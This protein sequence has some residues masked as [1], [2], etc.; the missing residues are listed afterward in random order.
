VGG[1]RER[2]HLPR[3]DGQG[4][5]LVDAIIPGRSRMEHDATHTTWKYLS[6]GTP[7]AGI[8]KVVVK[9]LAAKLPGR[10]RFSIS[11]RLPSFSVA[12]LA[13]PLKGTVVLDPPNAT[14]GQCVETA[15]DGELAKGCAFHRATSPLK[16]K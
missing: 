10:V 2:G 3:E 4:G 9:D 7:I 12:G 1:T 13:L 15:F 16:C 14:T 6:S 5:S 11:G 8:T